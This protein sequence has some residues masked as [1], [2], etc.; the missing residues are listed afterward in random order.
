[1]HFEYIAEAVSKGIMDVQLSQGTSEAPVIFGVLTCLTDEQALCR[2]G[3]LP[4]SHN[5]GTGN[6][7]SH[8]YQSPSSMM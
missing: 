4:G 3:L 1:M 2:A 6:L 8:Q 7:L 5:H